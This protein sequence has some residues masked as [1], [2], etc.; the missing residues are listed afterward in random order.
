MEKEMIKAAATK[1]EKQSAIIDAQLAY[2]YKELGGLRS[3]IGMLMQTMLALQPWDNFDDY[4]YE[5]VR[6]Y[7]RVGIYDGNHKLTDV[8]ILLSNDECVM[9]IEVKNT[10]NRMF[11]VNDHLER[12]EKL[13]KFPPAEV[14]GKTVL[15]AMACGVLDPELRDYAFSKG[16][17]VLHLTGDTV[18]LAETPLGFAPRE[19][20]SVS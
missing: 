12:M 20:A 5:F 9:V 13:V 6:A 17:F 15:G 18:A 11:D 10:L 3:N 4:P 14:K 16:L 1:R 7:E 8:D 19:W 2:M